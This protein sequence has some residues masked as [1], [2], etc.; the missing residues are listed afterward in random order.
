MWALQPIVQRYLRPERA[1][2]SKESD[3]DETVVLEKHIEAQ[4][5]FAEIDYPDD[6]RIICQAVDWESFFKDNE[7]L[8]DKA[9][10]IIDRSSSVE[11]QREVV[12]VGVV[13]ANEKAVILD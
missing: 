13:V 2:L 4:S 5:V 1:A 3:Q 6:E 7:S 8:Y 11:G 9:M 12:F 10:P